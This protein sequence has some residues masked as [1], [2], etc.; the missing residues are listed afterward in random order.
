MIFCNSIR[1]RQ[2]LNFQPQYQYQ[3]NPL[4]N[5][6]TNT[7]ENPNLNTNTQYQYLSKP[8]YP[9]PNTNTQCQYLSLEIP[10]SNDMDQTQSLSFLDNLFKWLNTAFLQCKFK[11]HTKQFCIFKKFRP[12]VFF[13]Q[14]V[15]FI[16]VQFVTI[17]CTVKNYSAENCLQQMWQGIRIVNI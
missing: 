17:F 8:Q 13:L 5:T 1:H 11:I 10:H 6:N 7:T 9:I 15:I 2:Y 16:L 14:I 12:A 4:C 3:T